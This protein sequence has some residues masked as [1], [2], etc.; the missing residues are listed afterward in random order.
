MG[1]ASWGGVCGE[2]N[3]VVVEMKSTNGQFYNV[4]VIICHLKIENSKTPIKI[5]IFPLYLICFTKHEL[6]F[7]F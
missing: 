6:K 5:Y 4:A 3:T 1:V 2:K 7:L